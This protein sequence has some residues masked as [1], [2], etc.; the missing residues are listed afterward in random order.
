MCDTL[1]K[2]VISESSSLEMNLAG[3]HLKFVTPIT[4]DDIGLDGGQRQNHIDIT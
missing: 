1:G 2:T 3:K 4:N